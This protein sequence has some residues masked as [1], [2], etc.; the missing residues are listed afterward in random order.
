MKSPLN[1]PARTGDCMICLETE[2]WLRSYCTMTFT[3]EVCHG[4]R[5]ICNY[6][7]GGFDMRPKENICVGCFE[8]RELPDK[9]RAKLRHEA[10]KY[11]QRG[12]SSSASSTQT[13]RRQVSQDTSEK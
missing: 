9:L 12:R 6:R 11:E 13:S 2:G 1:K 4:V 8:E 5:P 10:H 3:C 7:V